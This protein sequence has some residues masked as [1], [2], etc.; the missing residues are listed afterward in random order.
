MNIYNTWDSPL[1]HAVENNY[2]QCVSLL[3]EAGADVNTRYT[4]SDLLCLASREGHD[5]CLNLLIQAIG[6]C[7]KAYPD[8]LRF[9]AQNGHVKC[10]LLLIN[11]GTDVNAT[12]NY[13]PLMAAVD[14]D[15]VECASV[16]IKA[17]ADVNHEQSY[18]GRPLSGYT[19]S[20]EVTRLLLRSGAQINRSSYTYTLKEPVEELLLAAGETHLTQLTHSLPKADDLMGMC[21]K[22]IREHLL[23]LDPHTHLF[24]KVERLGLP[25]ALVRYLVF[26]QSLDNER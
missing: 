3:I 13:T 26:D 10:L 6:D 18:Y 15:H 4:Q 20:L 7:V 12:K 5:Q 21:R 17:G 24:S 25:A 16:L 9:A 8:P 19:Q 1:R 2:A 22:K 23:D 11:A 14:N